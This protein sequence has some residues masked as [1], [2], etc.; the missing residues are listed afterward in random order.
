M[1]E[2]NRSDHFE[3]P[4]IGECFYNDFITNPINIAVCKAYSYIFIF[5]RGCHTNLCVY[6]IFCKDNRIHFMVNHPK[7]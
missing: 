2:N 5:C 7:K 6:M 1:A 4:W 3:N